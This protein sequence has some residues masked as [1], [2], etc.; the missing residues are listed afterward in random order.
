LQQQPISW[1]YSG[2]KRRTV[3]SIKHFRVDNIVCVRTCITGCNLGTYENQGSFQSPTLLIILWCMLHSFS[4][5]TQFM[6]LYHTIDFSAY[7]TAKQLIPRILGND[8]YIASLADVETYDCRYQIQEPYHSIYYFSYDI[9][10]LLHP[11]ELIGMDDIVATCL[12]N[13]ILLHIYGVM[14]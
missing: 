4:S 2:T 9:S 14:V 3:Y 6:G 1:L 12:F 11:L 7:F 10:N 5:C 13:W 8:L